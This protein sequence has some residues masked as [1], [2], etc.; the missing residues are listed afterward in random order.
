MMSEEIKDKVL[1]YDALRLATDVAFRNFEGDK[2]L[3]EDDILK[4]A[5]KFSEF[6]LGKE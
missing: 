5:S 2:V 3:S 4:M 1:R 6:I